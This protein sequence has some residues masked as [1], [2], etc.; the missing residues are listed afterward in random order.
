MPFLDVNMFRENGKFVTNVYRKETFTGVYTNF[1]SFIP[2]EHKL[3]LVYT[4]LHRCFCLV[5]DMFKFHFEIEKLKEILLSNGYSN[6]FI[7]K[8]ISKFMNKLYIEKPVMSTVPKKQLYLVLPFIGKMPALVKPGLA[9]SLH[10]RLPFCKVKI[11]FKT[12][13]RLKNYFS[14]KDVVP[15]SL[16]SFQICNFMCGSCNASYIG[17]S[18]RHMKVRVLEHQGVSPRTG[19]HLKGTLS[20][21]LRDHMLDCNHIVA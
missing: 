7:E 13:N 14:F 11:A 19:K 1:S 17:K 5:S 12:S 18:F 20:T 10:K 9:R 21:S 15:E 6:K 8:C 3:G 4:L 16:R 2:L